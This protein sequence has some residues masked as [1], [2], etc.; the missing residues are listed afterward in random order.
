MKKRLLIV[1]DEPRLTESFKVIFE[2]KGFSVETS[3]N[4]QDAIE[5]FKQN[6][7]KVVL[8][9]IQMDKMDGIELMHVLKQLDPC[10]QII[11]LT[12]YSDVETAAKALKQNNAFEYLSKPVKDMN[13]LYKTIDQAQNKYDEK[14]RLANQ[15]KKNDKEFTIFRSIF[16]SLEA[17]VYVS[18]IK[19]HELIY[20]NKKLKKTFGQ[21]PHAPL[22]GQKCWEVLQ[23]DFTA[24]CPF[25]TNKRLLQP[26]GSPGEPYEWEFQNTANNRW[27]SIVDKAIEWYDKRIVRLETAF[28]ITEKKEHEKLFRE[29]E[30]AIETS[31]KLESIGTLAGGVAHDFNNTLSM[32]IGNINLAQLTSSNTETLNYLKKAE[33]G[34]IQAKNISS[35]LIAFAKG[36]GPLKT[37]IDIEKLIHQNFEKTF[38]PEKIIFSVKQ[39]I[40]PSPFYADQEQLITALGNIIQNSIE[41]MDGKGRIDVVIKYLEQALK[42]PRISISI[43][44]TGGGISREHLDMIFNPYFTT[45][46]LGSK[47]STGLG[48]SIA[49]SIIA[50][51]GGNIHV[52]STLEQGTTVHI[53]LP[54]FNET[55]PKKE[56]I[57]KTGQQTIP[58]LNKKDIKVLFMD[59]DPLT[60]DVISQLLRRLGYETLAASNGNQAI[61]LCKTAL[62]SHKKINVA[63]LD[64]DITRGLGGFQTM[65]SLIEADPCIK[66]ILITGHADNPD[67]QK[68]KKYGFSNMLE[69]PF[70]IDHL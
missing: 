46:P 41:A 16:D 47:K 9:D 50:R 33:T 45:K 18:D 25:C 67:I 66:G 62:V 8:S 39:D 55:A 15:K 48:L 24:P 19:T 49:W 37:E 13:L 4:G 35:K 11:F 54:I 40:I 2:N 36:G 14:K 57:E 10:V 1:D 38:D 28:D 20:T 53:F 23:K 32:I 6:P 22:E 42:S 7:F 34:I 63:L 3:S 30:K 29:F 26:D 65:K 52:E 44:D 59:D 21:N 17:I 27:Y 31:K 56:H 43:S 69:K 70:S 60:L 61:E 12:G 64:Y 5:R 68:Y 51:H 58:C